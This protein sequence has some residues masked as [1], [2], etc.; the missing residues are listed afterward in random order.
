MFRTFYIHSDLIQN[1]YSCEKE[2]EK[3][4]QMILNIK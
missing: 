1:D 2:C 3:E 4:G